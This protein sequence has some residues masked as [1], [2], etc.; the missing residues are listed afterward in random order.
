[1]NYIVYSS[2]EK[3][4]AFYEESENF[5]K[6]AKAQLETLFTKTALLEGENDSFSLCVRFAPMCDSFAFCVLFK[7]VVSNTEHRGHTAVVSWL[8]DSNQA[9]LL[10]GDNRATQFNT[11]ISTSKNILAKAGYVLDECEADFSATEKEATK[12]KILALYSSLILS[13]EAQTENG[14]NLQNQVF[15]GVNEKEEGYFSTLFTFLGMLPPKMRKKLSFY[16]GA[17]LACESYGVALTVFDDDKLSFIRQNNA[18]EGAMIMQKLI[19]CEKRISS[20]LPVCDKAEVFLGLNSADLE[21][22]CTVFAD[23]YDFERYLICAGKISKAGIEFSR[24][25]ELLEILGDNYAH[26]AF[27]NNFFTMG[28][29]KSVYA[30]R[31]KFADMPL[32]IESV[33]KLFEKEPKKTAKEKAQNPQKAFFGKKTVE[34]ADDS[35]IYA[36]DSEE[37]D[38]ITYDDDYS[39]NKQASSFFKK[40]S[41]ILVF[42]ITVAVIFAVPV[43]L[44]I[45]G[46]HSALVESTNTLVISFSQSGF[47]FALSL[48]IVTLAEL[49]LG[50]VLISLIKNIFKK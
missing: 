12:D 16:L 48:A 11:L 36:E 14:Y 13:E 23:S 40:L 1:M 5:P 39:E 7:G 26:I 41:L 8:L 27:E 30:D 25:Y 18:F 28:F 44:F 24:D 19:Y 2:G 50:Y 21:F 31:K 35:I 17:R 37:P 34:T 46:T 42:L 43:I 33:A 15:M 20:H 22:L 9:D 29:L 32:F 6:N 38:M 47:Y 4:Y 49:P 3:G 45:T 10:L